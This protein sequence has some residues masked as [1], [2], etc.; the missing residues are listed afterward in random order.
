M[1]QRG[2][3]A[4]V[5]LD[6]GIERGELLQVL[7]EDGRRRPHVEAQVD[8]ARLRRRHRAVVID[9]GQHLVVGGVEEIRVHLVGVDQREEVDLP[10]LLHG[11]DLPEL[12]PQK[13]HQRAVLAVAHLLAV[14][15]RGLRDAHALGD[16]G[17]RDGACDPVGI[18]VAA[19]RDEHVLALG[20]GQRFGECVCARLRRRPPASGSRRT[21]S[22]II[23]GGIVDTIWPTNP[24]RVTPERPPSPSPVR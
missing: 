18:G 19:Q 14:A 16:V 1:H 15:H 11:L 8:E 10:D 7:D 3:D 4:P 12:E 22:V 21:G 20:L 2:G 23:V 24:G 13:L 5:L 9:H 6:V 17:L